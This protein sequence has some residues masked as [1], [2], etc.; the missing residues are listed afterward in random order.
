M[1]CGQQIRFYGVGSHQQ[2]AIVELRIKELI[3]VS[4]KLLLHATRLWP[5]AVITIIVRDVT[6]WKWT[7]N[8]GTRAEIC[9]CEMPKFTKRLPHLG[10]PSICP[11]S[12]PE[13]GPDMIPK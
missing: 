1:T 4:Q 8:K 6:V 7:K 12:F 11:W 9:Q 10:L 3:L 13:F 5:E 2:N